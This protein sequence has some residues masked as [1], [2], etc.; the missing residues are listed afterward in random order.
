MTNKQKSYFFKLT[1]DDYTRLRK[2][3]KDGS[4]GSEAL[5]SAEEFEKGYFFFDCSSEQ[6][7]SIIKDTKYKFPAGK[8]LAN[9]IRQQWEA[10]SKA[11]TK[12]K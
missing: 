6:L 3:V 2:H 12:R 7:I 9:V 4:A 10:N 11:S 8:P 5:K 1:R